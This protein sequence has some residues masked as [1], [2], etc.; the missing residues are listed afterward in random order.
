MLHS[1]KHSWQERPFM[2]HRCSMGM[3][4]ITLLENL[5]IHVYLQRC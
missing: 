3:L 1:C 5:I 2:L 4:Q